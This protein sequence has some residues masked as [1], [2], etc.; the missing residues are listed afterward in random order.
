MSIDKSTVERI[1]ELS[2]LKFESSEQEAI[3][4]DMNRMLDFVEKLS[5]VD[6]EGVEPLVYMLDEKP[7]VRLDKVD[8]KTTQAEALKNAPDADSDYMKV[9]KVMKGR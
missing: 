8:Q 3:L 5:E 6:T 1:A 2:K 4:E 9:P 7:T